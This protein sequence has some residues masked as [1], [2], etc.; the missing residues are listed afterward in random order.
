MESSGVFT[1]DVRRANEQLA[2]IAYDGFY[3]LK[4]VQSAVA[5]RA[6]LVKVRL[7]DWWSEVGYFG[8]DMLPRASLFDSNQEASYLAFSVWRKRCHPA[9]P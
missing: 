5:A 3:L 9:T 7:G 1:L 6:R 2:R 8:R 4:L